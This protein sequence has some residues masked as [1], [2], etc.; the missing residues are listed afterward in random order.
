MKLFKLDFLSKCFFY[1]IKMKGHTPCPS[2][3][4]N[5]QTVPF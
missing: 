5:L 1:G 3:E 2:Q 4:G